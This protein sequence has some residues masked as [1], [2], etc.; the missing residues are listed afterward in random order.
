MN[1]KK[2]YIILWIFIFNTTALYGY[3]NGLRQSLAGGFLLIAIEF[4]KKNKKLS[5]LFFAFGFCFH[6]SIIIFSYIYIPFFFN[7]FK[8]LN[9]LE[10]NFILLICIPLSSIGGKFFVLNSEFLTYMNRATN[11][12]FYI[13]IILLWL[14]YNLYLSYKSKKLEIEYIFFTSF[15]LIILFLE[16]NHVANRYLYYINIFTPILIV[17]IF[18][19]RL[20]KQRFILIILVWVYHIFVLF[21]PST[22]VMFDF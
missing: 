20:K 9:K 11:N 3:V 12:S 2:Y 6:K 5:F 7:R 16:F 15:I 4:L 17:D 19:E 21:Y 18:F 1:K 8:N 14:F 13:K 10:K 22:R